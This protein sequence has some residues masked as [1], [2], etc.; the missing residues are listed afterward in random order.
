MDPGGTHQ[1]HA[2]DGG[3]QTGQVERPLAP[4]D[5]DEETEAESSDGETGVCARPDEARLVVWDAHLLAACQYPLRA[6]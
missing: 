1:E 6:G 5:V 4:D 3:D 2:K